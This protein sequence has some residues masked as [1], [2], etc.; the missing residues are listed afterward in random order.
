MN[1][2][3]KIGIIGA[4]RIGQIHAETVA[5]HIGAAEPVAIADVNL[6]A[7]TD[8]AI[9]CNIPQ[10]YNDHRAIMDDPSIDAVA[11]CS[12]TDTHVPFIMQAAEAGKH[13][14]CEKPIAIDLQEI[15]K[16][17]DVVERTGV[18]LH[19]GFHKR[20]DPGFLEARRL[21][22]RG[23][24]GEPRVLRITSRD[25]APPPLDYLK[26]S[27]GL[28]LDMTI[29]DFDMAR[30]L[31]GCEVTE[32]H[33]IGRV[34]VDPEIGSEAND[35]DTTVITLQF[36]NGAIGTIDNCRQSSYGYDQRV[37]WFGS[38]GQI[39]I[40]NTVPHTV[41]TSNASGIQGSVPPYFFLERYIDAYRAEFKAFIEALINDTPVPVSGLDG[42]MP[43][44]IGLAALQSLR[45]GRSVKLSEVEV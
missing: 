9:T 38:G 26:R 35:I 42:R 30:Y 31:M 11:I 10:V 27:G 41:V 12:S 1:P 32:V 22:E 21:I 2:P 3:L 5:F 20:F 25:P 23:S 45:E 14:F 16:A 40:G 36:E 15:D 33:A 18:K 34:M 4:G 17:L 44:V 24:Y 39:A 19:I 37:E 13:I 6:D 29:H 43:V 8:L 28:Y 7:A